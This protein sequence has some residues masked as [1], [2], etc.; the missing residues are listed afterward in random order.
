M[1]RPARGGTY[2]RKVTRKAPQPRAPVVTRGQHS[3]HDRTQIETGRVKASA[4]SVSPPE[5]WYEITIYV[6][7][8]CGSRRRGTPPAGTSDSGDHPRGGLRSLST[9]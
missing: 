4:N 5:R 1:G 6:V 9:L 8:R 7:T 3:Q 2:T